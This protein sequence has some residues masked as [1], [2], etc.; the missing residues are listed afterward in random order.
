[1]R[2][3]LVR[4]SDGSLLDVDEQRVVAVEELLDDLRAG[5]RF[6]VHRRSTGTGCTVEVLVD[7]LNA[8]LSGSPVHHD[9]LA[10]PLSLLRRAFR[11]DERGADRG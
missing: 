10:N 7:V 5:R 1:M 6:R 9:G 4:E 8:A 11:L 3:M 2:R